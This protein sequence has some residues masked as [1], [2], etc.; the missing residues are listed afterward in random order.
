MCLT[1]REAL[2]A[3]ITCSKH[4]VFF[5]TWLQEKF[6]AMLREQQKVIE[7]I[8]QKMASYQRAMQACA[9]SGGGAGR[10]HMFLSSAN[11][12]SLQCDTAV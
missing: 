8:D 1:V 3:F 10:H 5:K 2:T 4:N 9:G 12:S 7:S 11:T 6:M